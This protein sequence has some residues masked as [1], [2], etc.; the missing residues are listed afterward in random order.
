MH[1]VDS[2]YNI[3]PE[4]ETKKTITIGLPVYND[5]LFLEES[6]NSILHQTHKDFKL[7][8]GDDHSTDGSN[9]ICERVIATDGRVTYFRHKI[10]IGISRNME[11]LLSKADTEYF[12][13][14]GDDDLIADSYVEKM[15]AALEKN[16][17][18][19]VAFSTFAHIDDD[20]N[21]ISDKL[22][23][24]YS[25]NNTR[26]RVRNFIKNAHDEFGYAVFRTEKIRDVRFPV[27]H[28]PNSK[29]AYNNI[30]P[31]LL[32]YLSK[33]DYSHVYDEPLFLKRVKSPANTHHQT[34]YQSNGILES[35]AF[36]IRRLNLIH[37]SIKM[38]CI[39]KSRSFAL[40]FYPLLWWYWFV[41][42]SLQ[43]T[44]LL[45]KAV[46]IKIKST[47]IKKKQ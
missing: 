39:A 7:I 44:K 24:D 18:A 13:W 19:I 38:M 34:T 46:L 33:G 36:Y 27:W 43:Q 28:W 45:L 11:F 15:I 40:S 22:N 1:S 9:E 8:I 26:K 21:C 17:N 10:N 47:F 29:C 30:Y 3:I 4:N 23:Y 25:D 42:P 12:M 16:P 5:R 41:I 31:S 37:F 20:G 32:Y 14:A 2:N 6:I 35:F